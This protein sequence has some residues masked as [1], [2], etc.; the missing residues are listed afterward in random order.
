MAIARVR[1]KIDV[2]AARVWE[3]VSDFGNVSWFPGGDAEIKGSGPGMVRLIKVPNADPV[4]EELVSLDAGKR[5][6]TYIIPSGNPLPVTNYRA[7]M[8]VTE[9]G[10]DA[11]E[12]EWLCECEPAAGVPEG[13][14]VGAVENMY[15]VM[16]G[17]LRDAL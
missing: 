15:R 14:A 7:T 3:L 17:W 2:P 6:L 16:I 10:S 5:S 11:C 13:D 12:L 1:E 8:N 9:A 4:R